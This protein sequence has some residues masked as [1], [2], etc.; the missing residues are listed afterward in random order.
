MFHGR[1]QGLF[2]ERL[3][4]KC[5]LSAFDRTSGVSVELCDECLLDAEAP[6]KVEC[7]RWKRG[8]WKTLNIILPCE[9]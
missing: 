5:E 7:T 2:S 3:T 4:F 9:L 6:R 1:R 8:G